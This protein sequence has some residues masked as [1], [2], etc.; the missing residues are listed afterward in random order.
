MVKFFQF[1]FLWLAG[2]KKGRQE[3]QEILAWE[4]EQY[5]RMHKQTDDL[6]AAVDEIMTDST[7]D[8]L[9]SHRRYRAARSL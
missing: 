5:R 6:L 9:A 8:L 1:L 3:L 7:T 2:G 4:Q